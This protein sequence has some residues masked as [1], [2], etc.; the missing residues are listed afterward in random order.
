MIAQTTRA[1]R[2]DYELTSDNRH[3]VETTLS[4]LALPAPTLV[5]RPDAV[6]ITVNDV[7]DLSAWMFHLGG[8]IHRGPSADGASLWTL[9]TTT[10]ARANG[11]TVAILVHA[12]VVDGDAVL[13]DVRRAVANA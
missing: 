9:S 2:S 5:A 10:P 12:A 4:Y 6:H 11:S 13:V 1:P 3:A 8:E 7:D